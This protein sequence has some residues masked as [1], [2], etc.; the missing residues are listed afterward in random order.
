[1]GRGGGVPGELGSSA[2][3]TLTRARER[4]R[5]VEQPSDALRERVDVVRGHDQTGA[6]AS[7]RLGYAANI[8]GGYGSP[9]PSA[10]RRAPL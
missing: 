9:D 10:R 5:V 6:E 2:Q 8:V 7:H 3:R 1:M 4:I